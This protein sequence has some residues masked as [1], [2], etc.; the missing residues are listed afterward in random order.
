MDMEK[1][2]DQTGLGL[3]SFPFPQLQHFVEYKEQKGKLSWIGWL[4][5][6]V[7]FFKT[8]HMISQSPSPLSKEQDN[9]KNQAKLKE[10]HSPVYL[11]MKSLKSG[12]K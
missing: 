10:P 11:S 3:S 6:S 1:K 9:S 12:Q 2:Y 4:Y 7:D 5:K 8:C